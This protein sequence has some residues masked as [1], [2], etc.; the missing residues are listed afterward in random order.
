MPSRGAQDLIRQGVMAL[1]SFT[2]F[3]QMGEEAAK[4][5]AVLGAGKPVK[6]S[7]TLNNRLKDVPW[8]KI[9]NVNV[10]RDT[11]EQTAKEN[12]WWFKARA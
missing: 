10:A 6:A 11:I 5:A 2:A 4:A 3:D 7:A 1:S 12:P 9:R 8:I